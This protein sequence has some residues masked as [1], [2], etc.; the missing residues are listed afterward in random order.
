MFKIVQTP[1]K[2]AS[3]QVLQNQNLCTAKNA[4][5]FHKSDKKVRKSQ[6]PRTRTTQVTKVVIGSS[7]ERVC[8]W[9]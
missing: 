5:D 1:V 3:T 8:N 7:A 9:K 2:L 6:T 4:S